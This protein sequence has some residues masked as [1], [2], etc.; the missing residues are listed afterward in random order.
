[1]RLLALALPLFVLWAVEL[2][3]VVQASSPP[4]W[5]LVDPASVPTPWQFCLEADETTLS[6]YQ[7]A[8]T[9]R[10]PVVTAPDGTVLVYVDVPAAPPVVPPSSLPPGFRDVTVGV[11]CFAGLPVPFWP[12]TMFCLP[13]HSP[14]S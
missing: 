7:V 9:T 4:C 10:V 5:S 12:R 8:P 13:T 3:W 11:D 14:V 1:V 2:G 6:A